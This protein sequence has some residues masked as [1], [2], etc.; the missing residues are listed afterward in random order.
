M[1]QCILIIWLSIVCAWSAHLLHILAAKSEPPA[2]YIY[3]S[4]LI[5][6]YIA[7]LP[8]YILLSSVGLLIAL[9]LR[10][11]DRIIGEDDEEDKGQRGNKEV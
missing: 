4:I 7:A 3:N 6:L 9:L 8:A 5:L 2:K 10:F 1:I 11:N